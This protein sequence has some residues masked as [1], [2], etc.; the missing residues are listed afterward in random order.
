MPLLYIAV[1]WVV[2]LV[3]G[4]FISLPWYFFFAGLLP[5][6]LI[7][8]YRSLH[9]LLLLV[10]ICLFAVGLGS[11]RYSS[12][13][14][15]EQNSSITVP[16][17][18][19]GT[20]IVQ[21]MVD[22]PP[23]LR[24]K[25]QLLHL[26]VTESRVLGKMERVH[27]SILV[28][29]AR[30]PAYQY[31]DL[32]SVAGKI[33]EEDDSGFDYRRYLKSRGA[34]L[35]LDFP[36]IEILARD[37]GSTWL[38]Y[39]YLT[40]EKLYSVIRVVLPEPQASLANGTAF[41]ITGDIPP[42][43]YDAFRKSGTTHILAISGLNLSIL[44]GAVLAAVVPVLGRRY[45][46]HVWIALISIWIFAIFSG[47]RPPVMRGAVMGSF[48]LAADLFGRQKHGLMALFLAAAILVG[49]DPGL[50]YSVSFQLSFMAMVGLIFIATPLSNWL[51][52][53]LT[54]L[55][56]LKKKS[57]SLTFLKAVA[58]NVSVTLGAT[59]FT[60]PLIL[61]Y[62]GAI[63]LVGV[64]ATLLAQLALMPIIV[65]TFFAAGA[66][67]VFLPLANAIGWLDYVFLRYMTAI[68]ENFSYLPGS[69]LATGY[70]NS[71]QTI[72]LYT[73]LVVTIVGLMARE[74]I[75]EGLVKV[76]MRIGQSITWLLEY[77]WKIPKKIVLSLLLI[78]TILVWTAALSLPDD[79]L[80]LS[81]IGSGEG[82]AYLIQ[83]RGLN[84]LIDGGSASR[85]TLL[86]L[87]ER[88][89][90]WQRKLDAVI[91]TSPSADQL[92][93]LLEVVKRYQVNLMLE[94]REKANTQIYREW[95]QIVD[96][97]PVKMEM[98]ANDTQ[99]KLGQDLTLEFLIVE[100][101]DGAASNRDTATA[102][103][104]NHGEISFFLFTENTYEIEGALLSSRKSLASTVLKMAYPENYRDTSVDFIRAVSPQVIFLTG[105]TIESPALPVSASLKQ[106][107]G[108][109][110]EVSVFS[111]KQNKTIELISDGRKLWVKNSE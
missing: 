92:N 78:F 106:A 54:K 79:R 4:V 85:Q 16:P 64:P 25:V 109:P 13:E 98:Y 72:L 19:A 30:Y 53:R 5:L 1:A 15:E 96:D 68:V 33:K 20:V 7:T 71:W 52:D 88:L 39:I 95:R 104:L 29:V 102:I 100:K 42:S 93:G 8:K 34:S 59:F 58:D 3:S 60:L 31:G 110:P 65:L 105:A 23:D 70:L 49:F 67:L 76:K 46:I 50:I 91:L 107:L 18:Y 17:G 94:C 51:G 41:G 99:I 87:G 43:L 47:S 21:G 24:E 22:E 45:Q 90:F 48:Y 63:S 11:L 61:Y 83:Y 108:I 80:H 103:K 56:G 37:R 32:L 35:A 44:M 101:N 86:A 75:K 97:L 9:R 73:L 2:G 69:S 62:F 74:K 14:S 38:K 12:F 28:M 82:E 57:T 10:A 55:A 36:R 84:V 111:C 66:G 6:A 27:T 26:S 77:L 81:L 89:P 40:R